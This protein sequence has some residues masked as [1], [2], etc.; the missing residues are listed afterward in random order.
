MEIFGVEVPRTPTYERMCEQSR[1]RKQQIDRIGL[2][3]F[4]RFLP[5]TILFRGSHHFQAGDPLAAILE[6]MR[7][8]GFHP[9]TPE[10][11]NLIRKQVFRPRAKDP[12]L[13]S[14][15]VIRDS[16]GRPVGPTVFLPMEY[17]QLSIGIRWPASSR[18]LSTNRCGAVSV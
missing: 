18:S 15:F 12:H 5:Q 8:E 16:D 7:K 9:L 3:N 13:D 2:Q 4:D 17:F 10:L 6:N 14:N 1:Q 11:K